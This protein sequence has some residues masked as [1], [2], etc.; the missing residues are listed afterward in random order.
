MKSP[1]E[2]IG[3]VGVCIYC[4]AAEG[5]LSDEHIV[6]L[7]LGGIW[8]L[9]KASCPNCQNITSA[10]EL[11]V[12]R[13]TLLQARAKLGLPSRHD[14]QMPGE[15]PLI[16]AGKG[17]QHTILVPVEKHPTILFLP[18]FKPPAYIDKRHYKAGIDVEGVYIYQLGCFSPQDFA[19]KSSLDSLTLLSRVGR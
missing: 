2:V 3:S 10:I 1:K 7:G 18:R 4:G 15:L 5:Q 9:R 13:Y 8:V 11:D 17:R 19:K 14:R 6:P 12:L 16:V